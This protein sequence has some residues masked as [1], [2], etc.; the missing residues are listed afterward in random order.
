MS[1]ESVDKKLFANVYKHKNANKISSIN[2]KDIKILRLDASGY[3][4]SNE[5]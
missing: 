1:L 3:D 5:S 4:E 2:L